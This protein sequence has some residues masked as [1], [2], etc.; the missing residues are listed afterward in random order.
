MGVHLRDPELLNTPHTPEMWHDA[1]RRHAHS[2]PGERSQS[3]NGVGDQARAE[4][5]DRLD[6]D[7]ES[8]PG[9]GKGVLEP[10]E[11]GPTT[12]AGLPMT[13]PSIPTQPQQAATQGKAAPEAIGSSGQPAHIINLETLMKEAEAAQSALAA[14]QESG[15]GEEI[16][17]RIREAMG[18]KV[19]NAEHAKP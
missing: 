7:V 5:Q 9:L 15:M 19:T 18:L 16:R 4:E 3:A 12:V 11:S 1:S 6:E 2:R 17:S 13:Q 8:P 10:G 14:A